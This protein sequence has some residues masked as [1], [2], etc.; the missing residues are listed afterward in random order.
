MDNLQ[1]PDAFSLILA[2]SSP[3]R[4]ALLRQIGLSFEIVPAQCQEIVEPGV[5]PAHTVEQLSFIKA[6]HVADQAQKA[7]VIGADTLVVLNDVFLGK[8]SDAAD[9]KKTL[10]SLSGQTHQVYTGVT[11]IHT[12]TGKTHIF[13][14]KT[15]VTFGDLTE[16]EIDAY[17][18]T[19]SPMDKAGAYGIQDDLG[20]LFVKKISGDYYNVVGFPL[21]RFYKEVNKHMPDIVTPFNRKP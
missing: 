18:K 19:G 16:Q 2:S 10:R 6:Q 11:L 12:E 1:K 3:R 9:A 8:P 14:E 7:L 21:Y 5:G 4:A 17:I 20:A 13:H 15:D